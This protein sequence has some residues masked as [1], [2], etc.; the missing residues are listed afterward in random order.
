MARKLAFGRVL[1]VAEDA[2]RVAINQDRIRLTQRGKLCC[3]LRNGEDWLVRIKGKC[4]NGEVLAILRIAPDRGGPLHVEWP[5]RRNPA[6]AACL[7]ELAA[8]KRCDA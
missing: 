2:A 4:K 3:H 1:H 5:C 8:R 7:I 6:H